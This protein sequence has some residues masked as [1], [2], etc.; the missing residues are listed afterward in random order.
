MRQIDGAM[1]F[2]RDDRPFSAVFQ[3]DERAD[4]NAFNVGLGDDGGA[5]DS[6]V[7]MEGGLDFAQFDSIAAFFNHAVA[8]A[9]EFITTVAGINDEVSGSIPRD[10]AVVLKKGPRGQVFATEI[11]ASDS[12]AGDDQFAD[13]SR[14]EVSAGFVD[15]ATSQRRANRTDREGGLAIVVNGFGDA[16]RG[17][18]VGFGR[19]VKVPKLGT[20]PLRAEASQ[21]LDREDLAGEEDE[22]RRV[23]PFAIDAAALSQKSQNRGRG[24]PDVN[25]AILE[26]V[27]ESNGVFRERFTDQHKS[28]RLPTRDVEIEDRQIEMWACDE[29]RS[30]ALVEKA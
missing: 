24:I 22:S 17:A 14:R 5:I 4:G 18:D 30:S 19:A 23:K 12:R 2:H 20:G 25:V 11:T 21:V 1:F 15:D 26:E 28:R 3:G 7:A 10:S 27:G 9:S 6:F 16:K 8:A 13:R 29:K